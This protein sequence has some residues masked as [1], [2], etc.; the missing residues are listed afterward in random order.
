LKAAAARDGSGRGGWF[1]LAAVLLLYAATALGSPGLA[2]EALAFSFNM[3]DQA[4][5]VLGIV[6]ALIFLFEL[7]LN[8]RRVEAYLGATSGLWGWAVAVGAGILATG[9]VYA[10]YALI[11]ELRAKGMKAS[12]AAAF[13]YARAVKFPLLPLLIHYFGL[14]YTVVLSVYLVIA[15]VLSGLFMGWIERSATREPQH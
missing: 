11:G 5:P 1:F 6:F 14:T 2:M 8:P 4:I 15:A 12:L 9:P 13:L 10:W 7:F 3:L